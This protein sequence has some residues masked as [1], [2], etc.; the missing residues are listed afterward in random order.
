MSN[1][2]KGVFRHFWEDLINPTFLPLKLIF[3]LFFGGAMTLWPFMTIF[4]RSMGISAEEIGL[5][6]S[7]TPIL[8]LL[9]PPFA[10]M[11]ADRIGNFKVLLSSMM[12]LAASVAPLFLLVPP[13]RATH[14]L[15]SQLPFNLT[16]SSSAPKSPQLV[17][18]PP[19]EC[20][21]TDVK[22]VLLTVKS[23]T[24]CRSFSGTCDSGGPPSED[25]LKEP[26]ALENA[27]QAL[28]LHSSV[29]NE[30][31]GHSEFD[32]EFLVPGNFTC[33]SMMPPTRRKATTDATAEAPPCVLSCQALTPRDQLCHNNQT[34]EVFSPFNTCIACLLVRIIH[35]SL[36]SVCYALATGAIMAVLVEDN[37]DYGLQRLYLN[38]GSMLLTPLSGVLIDYASEV[39]GY[40][41]YRPAIFLNSS[42]ILLCSLMNLFVNLEFRQPNKNI[43][44]DCKVLLKQGRISVFL[45]VMTLSGACFGLLETFLFLFLEDLG[46]TKGL[47]GLSLT[48]GHMA[49]IF[50]LIV[51]RAIIDWAGY[52]N[53][54]VFGFCT[55]SLRLLGYSFIYN[56]WMVMPFEALECFSV[57]LKIAAATTYAAALAT[58]TTLATLQGIKNGL[59][60][61][62]G[63]GL[64]SLIGGFLLKPL[65]PRWT[66]RLTAL[67]T[68]VVALSYLFIHM[69][70]FRRSEYTRFDESPSEESNGKTTE[71]TRMNPQK[72]KRVH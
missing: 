53:T 55:L 68:L 33:P 40:P 3:F 42:L 13:A 8:G 27:I 35:T 62:V 63:H 41:D 36:M 34:V 54:I 39:N 51:S 6:Y 66:F 30:G 5:I 61:G 71:E 49:G 44:F 64:G 59:H 31:E 72:D 37:G 24:T 25:C 15:P 23:C 70:F 52:V 38:L 21:I 47:M 32:R 57:A 43:A 12:V 20:D 14:D 22:R 7:V 11:L 46:A 16:C 2:S 1:L 4:M 29:G 28:V 67:V 18:S 50:V 9:V 56:P 17:L 19:Y 58:P 65:G 45:V 69:A 60:Y 48:V 10:G 26:L